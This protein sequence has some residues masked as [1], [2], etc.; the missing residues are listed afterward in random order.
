RKLDL[1]L[2]LAVG[3]EFDAALLAS[4]QARLHHG[5]SV[6]RRFGV[7]KP[8]VDG[9]LNLAEVDLIEH[10]G[11]RRVA[12][13]A[14]RQAPVE[15]HLAAFEALVAIAGARGLTLAAAASGLAYAGA[16][17]APDAHALFARARLVRDLIE[18]H[19]SVLL[20][21]ISD[22][23]HKVLDLAD[24]AAGCGR[25]RKVA[26][27]PDLVEAEPDQR[28]PLIKVTPLRAAH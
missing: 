9:S 27:A 1:C 4:H 3:Q 23:A 5:G 6:D 8:R 17:A 12:K 21:R 25:V 2:D 20:L 26:C 10:Q 18:F 24:H 11:K 7:D 13:S 19:R 16:D 15:R 28:L 22:N 14:L